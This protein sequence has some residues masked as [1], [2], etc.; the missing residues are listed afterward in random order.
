M[1]RRLADMR[2]EV[3]ENMRGGGGSV[4]IRHCFEKSEITAN[5]RLC[6]E[7][8]IPPGAGIGPHAHEKEDEVFIITR[9]S[10]LL[11]DGATE[12]RVS[13]GDAILTGNGESHSIHNDGQEPLE[14]VAVIMCY[15]A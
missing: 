12:T 9:G 8:V 13:A 1:I 5:S 15:S 14:L 6:A 3:R 10:G 2:E 11:N 4:T 7:L